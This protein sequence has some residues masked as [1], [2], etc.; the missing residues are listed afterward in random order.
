[1]ELR[2]SKTQVSLDP[3]TLKKRQANATKVKR[4]R[5]NRKKDKNRDEQLKE[6]DRNRK[7]EER[8]KQRKEAT[9]NSMA[10]ENLKRNKLEEVKRYRQRKKEKEVNKVREVEQHTVLKEKKVMQKKMVIQRTQQWRMKVKLK[11]H[12]QTNEDQPTACDI[13][14]ASPT[15]TRSYSSRFARYRQMKKLKQLCQ[16]RQHEK[17][18]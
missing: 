15:R 2:S 14:D 11:E 8:H 18:R 16:K 12:G 9:H 13:T 17:L 4:W 10:L 5:E 1:M 7:R 6:K 3:A